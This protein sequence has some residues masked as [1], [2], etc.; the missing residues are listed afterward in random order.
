MK[1]TLK[2]IIKFIFLFLIGA[3]V[4]L[5]IYWL[6]NSIFNAE[7]SKSAIIVNTITDGIILCVAALI[8]QRVSDKREKNK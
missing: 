1:H 5:L 2:V 4:A 6:G 7:L 3:A 8:F